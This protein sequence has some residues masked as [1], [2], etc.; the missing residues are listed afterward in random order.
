MK[1]K[2]LLLILFLL[3]RWY[4]Y[5]HPPV[6][7]SDVFHDYRRYASMWASGI[8][9]YFKHL[10]E[11]PPATIPLLYFPEFLNRQNIG[12]YYENYRLQILL[13]DTIFFLLIFKRVKTLSL[14]F[15]IISTTIAKDFLYEGLDLVFFGTLSLA[16]I[17]YS[18][19]IL[20]WFLFWL[21]VSLKLLTAPL[22]IPYF[23]LAKKPFFQEA[24]TSLIGFLLVWGLPLVFFRSSLLVMF[25][26]HGVRGLKYA[27][28]PSYIVETINNFTHSEVRLNQPPDFQ[29]Q[30]PISDIVS[31]IT[32]LVFPLSIALVLIYCLIKIYKP[33][34]L[35]YYVFGLKLALI[36]IFTIFLTGKIFSQ[37]FH[38]WFIPLITIFPFKS[39]KQQLIFM[40]LG[41]WLLIIDTTPWIRV[42]EGLMII[43]P[44]P[45]KFFI[46]SLRFLPMF[47]LLSLSYKLPD[48]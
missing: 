16:L 47:I 7:Y 27:S 29:L 32:S 44:L 2:L 39:I 3:T 1:Q 24:K 30:G 18:R 48:K 40:F 26:F 20:F 37:P 21:S 38:I 6:N 19:R 33:Q 15:Y 25:F 46:Y 10:Y 31:Y 42:N 41:I 14:I 36:Y 8:T 9:P 5:S 35:N 28:F 34:P 4:I 22:V 23:F 17:Y 12:H 13:F 11:Y 45:L 43:D